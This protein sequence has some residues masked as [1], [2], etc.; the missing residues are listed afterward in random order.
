MSKIVKNIII[1][2][3]I[4]ALLA[5]GFWWLLFYE[6]ADNSQGDEIN[7]P[8]VFEVYKKPSEDVKRLELS[9]PESTIIFNNEGESWGIEGV[10]KDRISLS[11]VDGFASSALNIYSREKVTENVEL[12]GFDSPSAVISVVG[13]DGK[14]DKIT[15]GAKSAVADKVFVNVNGG[16]A[17]TMSLSPAEALMEDMDYY[18]SFRRFDINLDEIYDIEVKRAKNTYHLSKTGETW[19][20]T[21]PFGTG[22]NINYDFIKPGILE[23]V[24]GLELTTPANEKLISTSSSSKPSVATILTAPI[25]SDGTMG[26]TTKTVLYIGRTE[27][28]KTYV[29][30]D[31]EVFAVP[32]NALSFVDADEMHIVSKLIAIT[33]VKTVNSVKITGADTEYTLDVMHTDIGTAEDETSFKLNGQF[34]DQKNLRQA[35]VE[36]IS[37]QADENY[38]GQKKGELVAK[39]ELDTINGAKVLEFNKIDDYI[40]T[41]TVNG[42]TEFVIKNSKVSKMLDAFDALL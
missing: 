19:L 38:K 22:Y 24:A 36:I 7:V 11:K 29:E 1:F 8:E 2:V 9:L 31:G 28:D 4:L 27:G 17:W 33:D 6:P 12:C 20:I 26:E 35:Y 14:T 42:S 21:E 3:I 39:V 10:E 30:Y 34:L 18:R 32:T 5:F 15:L 25:L 40:C 41:F 16:D 13:K 23:L 37:L